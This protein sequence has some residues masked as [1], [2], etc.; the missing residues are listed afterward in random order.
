MSG[1]SH[2]VGVVVC[3]DVHCTSNMFTAKVVTSSRF[4][5]VLVLL[6]LLEL[7][8]LVVRCLFFLFVGTTWNIISTAGI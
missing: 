6:A 7:E 5:Q 8:E 3:V 2:C 1:V 4:N